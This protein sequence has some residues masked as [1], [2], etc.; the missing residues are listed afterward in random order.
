MMQTY[1]R[2][3]V[4]EGTIFRV[5]QALYINLAPEGRFGYRRQEIPALGE[6]PGYAAEA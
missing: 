5:V 3:G 4:P 1:S 6:G 2:V